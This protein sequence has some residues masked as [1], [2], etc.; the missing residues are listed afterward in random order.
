MS[1]PINTPRAKSTTHV[2]AQLAH[3][4]RPQT[5]DT[6]MSLISRLNTSYN[7]SD[8]K[9]GLGRDYWLDD[10]TATKCRDCD[11]KFTTFLRKHHCRICG[12]IFCHNCTRFIEGAKFNHK[13][14]MRVCF[15][16]D[17]KLENYENYNSSDEEM[18][19]TIQHQT[20]SPSNSQSNSTFHGIGNS[21]TPLRSAADR[22]LH[23]LDLDIPK[24]HNAKIRQ[25]GA[26]VKSPLVNNIR[27]NCSSENST[28]SN[29]DLSDEDNH[30][31]GDEDEDDRQGMITL[32]NNHEFNW[33]SNG[34]D[35]IKK[36]TNLNTINN[37][38]GIFEPSSKFR[39][40]KLMLHKLKSK[41]TAQRRRNF[42]SRYNH[43][44]TT[45]RIT[46]S[47]ANLS[48]NFKLININ[49]DIHF[50][51]DLQKASE[52]YNKLLLK[53]L[54]ND[55]QI[56]NADEW[57]EILF[58]S[59][60]KINNIDIELNRNQDGTTYDFIDYIKFKKIQG[61]KYS[62]TEPLE[63]LVFS[64]KLP[65]RKM[66]LKI[67][68]PKVMII[69]FG[70]EYDQNIDGE[71]NFQSLDSV[72][73][74]QDEYLKKLTDRIIQLKP[75]IIISSNSI[76]VLA[77]KLLAENGIAAAPNCKLNNIIK[78][79]KFTNSTIITSID[80]LARK[81]ELGKCECFE[82]RYFVSH[83]LLKSYFFF[84]GCNS[85]IGLTILL[86]GPDIETLNKIKACLTPM[87]YAFV[88]TNLESSFLRD[89]Y[90]K[91]SDRV[92]SD[93]IHRVIT[94]PLYTINLETFDDIVKL[95]EERLIST[96]PWVKFNTPII[97][98]EIKDTMKKLELVKLNYIEFQ[99][100]KDKMAN[101][102]KFKKQFQFE[103]LEIGNEVDL[104]KIIDS[105]KI[106]L[107]N[108]LS[109]ELTFLY[110]QWAQFWTSRDYTFFDPN[111][112]QNIATLFS[113]ISSKNST[114]CI[115]PRLQMIDFYW[116]SD[117]SI[118]QYIE[119]LCSQ[120]EQ[121]C[122]NG[123]GLPLKDHYSSYVH[124][125]GKI[126]VKLELINSEGVKSNSIITWSECKR[127]GKTTNQM[128][129][130]DLSSKYSFGK[131]LELIFWYDKSLLKVGSINCDCPNL[132]FFKDFIHLFS[133][134]DYIVKFEYQKIDILQLV[135]PKFKVFWDP[136]Y[137]YKIKSDYYNYVGKKS[138]KFF[139]SVDNRLNTIKLDSTYVDGDHL[140]RGELKLSELKELL[141]K[142][143][144]EIN[145]LLRKVYDNSAISDHL[146]LNAVL[147]E[148][149]ELS[150]FWKL[151]FDDFEKD[152]LPTVR[153]MKSNF[154]LERLLNVLANKD[155]DEDEGGP[156]D[157]DNDDDSG[158]EI[159][160]KI[161][162]IEV[163]KSV[164]PDNKPLKKKSDLILHRINELNESFGN[165]KSNDSINLPHFDGLDV[166]QVKKLK[167]LFEDDTKDF[168]N[169]REKMEM[170]KNANREK[171]LPKVGTMNPQVKIYK[172]AQD[173]QESRTQTH[174]STPDED[175]KELDL[176]NEMNG[177]GT[178]V[179]DDKN[180]FIK[181][182]N[183]FIDT[184]T[185]T[186][187]TDLCYPLGTLEHIFVDS[188]VIVRE[189]EPSSIV[190]FCLSTKDY[191]SKLYTNRKQGEEEGE[192][193]IDDDY[194]KTI[195]LK[196]GFHLNYQFEGGNSSSIIMCKI[197][198]AEQ[199]DA[200]R[201]KCGINDNFIS[202]TSRCIKWD[203]TG[204]KSG[205][206][207]LKTLDD[208]FIIKELGK[209]EMEAFTQM[210]HNYFEY[211]EQ[212]M[213]NGLPSVLAKI[214]GLF[215][216]QVKSSSTKSYT[217]DVVITENLFYNKITD[218]IF[219][220][221]GSMRNRHVEQT[222]KANEVLLDENMVE[223][224]YESPVF[225]KENDK[226][227]LRA[228]LWNDT[229]FL[230][231]MNVM[232]YS[233]VVGIDSLNKQLVVGIID[234]IR[235]FTWDKKLESWVK[236]KG[237]VGSSG[238]GKEPT[239]ITPKQYKNRFREAMERYIL[240][241][242]GAFYQGTKTKTS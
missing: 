111:Y 216:I 106:Y 210:A 122:L 99:D 48:N 114:P 193:E 240:L 49:S 30:D 4:E 201:R 238:V 31:E 58:K 24:L 8:L 33:P 119:R 42:S 77:L 47:S 182:M 188:D 241:A 128:P 186:S 17:N 199:F 36:F 73:A 103:S 11:R 200:L 132:D 88:N 64:K 165:D 100:E 180:W 12:K 223:Y 194:L 148:V 101:L 46:S 74:Q 164:T 37:S 236:E 117:E 209:S 52:N 189:D 190:S 2:I 7:E 40:D 59:L 44:S 130:N 94:A 85:K 197:F 82:Q 191:E 153:E 84:T 127:C 163:D 232:D 118:G 113:M 173:A 90:L 167:Q 233:L 76:H 65:L 229:L 107:D 160:D 166:G 145:N 218:R 203:S 227:I 91:F 219:D 104:I 92:N 149:Q 50:T 134:N 62:D 126:D 131:F 184:R 146:K 226:K 71:Q 187:W 20:T 89:K 138:N 13:G 215:Q 237:L 27:D 172:N 141:F 214:F 170:L 3:N 116:D 222:G 205:A 204:G 177:E 98:D 142:H 53:E 125:D 235:T 81:P 159:N 202:S 45:S 112:N 39:K 54:I 192:K 120:S 32:M 5:D 102:G 14:M 185:S 56:V 171:Y 155:E 96:S 124:H 21:P 137:D 178:R 213:F 9:T 147:R 15:F 75:D 168:F 115:G 169:E 43:H 151:E 61:G 225:V 208:R 68:N 78:L 93:E 179:S 136:E 176:I 195:F 25:P 224:I 217:I 121:I 86:R 70:I 1:N 181:I 152:F 242:P 10:A 230:E 211:F 231:K 41:S 22:S 198:F 129:L 139:D 143:R 175:A 51:D 57:T 140:K 183:N 23:R 28:D 19:E 105:M 26:S 16:C 162:E 144:E 212:V 6:S 158:K 79:S 154:Q 87:V 221:K 67:L 123:C 18:D 97:L 239:V 220:L 60:Q 95:T 63:G 29:I 38:K 174:I 55:K 83:D 35:F 72:I 80:M 206:A 234:C 161:M 133:F 135:T 34:T 150:S 110:R 66:P 196:S 109:S 207:F 69:T 157:D 108:F 228:S 156:E